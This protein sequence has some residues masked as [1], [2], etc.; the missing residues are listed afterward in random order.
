M[1]R[2]TQARRRSDRVVVITWSSFNNDPFERELDGTYRGGKGQHLDGPTLT[3]VGA[4]GGALYGRVSRIVVLYRDG[5]GE[6]PQRSLHGREADV[7]TAL[8]EE[9]QRRHPN[10]EVDMRS[11]RTDASP[12][13]HLMIYQFVSRVLADVRR[14]EPNARIVIS[15]SPGTPA[16][17]AC[18]VLAV[19]SGA[20]SGDVCMVQGLRERDRKPGQGPLVRVELDA[21][22]AVRTRLQ[23][24]AEAQRGR[25]VAA[26]WGFETARSTAGREVAARVHQASRHGQPVLLVGERG[27]G[28]STLARQLHRSHPRYRAGVLQERA[29]GEFTSAELFAAE[30]FG[31]APGSFTGGLANGKRGTLEQVHLGTLFLD[32]ITDLVRINQRALM[33]VLQT[34]EFTPVGSTQA[35]TSD[36]RLICATNRTDVELREALF[37]DFLD[38]ITASTIRVP[39]LRELGEDLE[40]IWRVAWGEA[41]A[42]TEALLGLSAL[43][44][45][46][47][48]HQQVAAVLAADDLPGNWRDLRL[49]ATML[50]ER[51]P[52]GG[53]GWEAATAACLGDF[54]RRPRRSFQAHALIPSVPELAATLPAA[55]LDAKMLIRTLQRRLAEAAVQRFG[56]QEAAGRGLGVGQTTVSGWLAS[57]DERVVGGDETTR[58]GAAGRRQRGKNDE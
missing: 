38:R 1:G 51:L 43:D 48:F 52:E 13:D 47:G 5:I 27:T 35:E 6:G 4:G 29:C 37:P 54:R 56:S 34:N 57:G 2:P 40:G 10:V 32:E 21:E 8:R 45:E 9:L 33:R 24:E 15:I 11:W 39:S 31:Y 14:Q 26:G 36:F 28:K 3:V 41:V 49:L 42:D 19:G 44:E 25:V 23:L 30:M 46:R 58:Q 50:V 20:L 53:V 16:M 55:G 17:H 22:R 7:A 18:W 12:I